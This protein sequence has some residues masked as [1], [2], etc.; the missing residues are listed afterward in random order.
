MMYTFV[1]SSPAFRNTKLPE[2][3]GQFWLSFAKYYINN[4]DQLLKVLTW[5]VDNVDNSQLNPVASFVANKVMR[6]LV[7]KFGQNA[8]RIKDSELDREF[9]V[10]IKRVRDNKGKFDTKAKVG[11]AVENVISKRELSLEL[12]SIANSQ[13][14]AATTEPSTD[15][16]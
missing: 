5:A 11:E 16:V 4:R 3:I 14:N 6:N 2:M 8:Y 15:T 9:V 13:K 12:K 10:Q 7:A 1:E